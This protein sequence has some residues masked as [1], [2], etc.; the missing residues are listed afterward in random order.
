M[1]CAPFQ[2]GSGK[3]VG[4]IA[5]VQDVTERKVAEDKINNLAFYDPLT[6]LPNRRLLLDR[7][8]HALA[9]SARSGKEGALLFIDLD[10]FK[11][12]NDTLGHDMGDLLLQTGRPT[13]DFL[14]A[15]RRL[16]GASGR[17]R[18]RGDAGRLGRTGS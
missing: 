5:I 9:S 7:L 6:N 18:V 13:P 11:A 10:N 14:C 15:R 2:D 8:Q 4:G 17:R 3:I 1:T 16:C 12:L